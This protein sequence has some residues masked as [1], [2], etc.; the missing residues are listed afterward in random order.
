MVF[1]DGLLFSHMTVEQNLAFGAADKL[2]DARLIELLDLNALRSKRV[3]ELSAG[4][5]QRVALARTL[6]AEPKMVLLDAPL[7]SLDPSARTHA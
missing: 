1:D 2:V 6:A 7:T 3:Q 4:Q 5:R